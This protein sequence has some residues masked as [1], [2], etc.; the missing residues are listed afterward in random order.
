MTDT[1]PRDHDHPLA[2]TVQPSVEDN[3]SG[4]RWVHK[5]LVQVRQDWVIGPPIVEEAFGD[6]E[7]WASYICR[8][9]EVGNSVIRRNGAGLQATADYNSNIGTPACTPW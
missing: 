9:A 2:A 4:A 5:D 8:F 7:C 6:V 1:L 3:Q